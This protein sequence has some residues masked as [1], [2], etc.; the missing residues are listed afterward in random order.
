VQYWRLLRQP[1]SLLLWIGQVLSAAGDRLYAMAVLWLALELT[2]STEVMAAISAAESMVTMAVGLLI[3]A[4]ID[5]W[6]RVRTILT[7]DVI[8]AVIV[9]A[10]PVAYLC[11]KLDASLIVALC[12]GMAALD[13]VFNPALDA[14]LP[15]LVPAHQLPGLAGLMDTP[16]RFARLFGPGLAGVILTWI[17]VVGFYAIDA[18]TFAFSAL[19]LYLVR[20]LLKRKGRDSDSQQARVC[21]DNNWLQEATG[22]LRVVCKDELLALVLAMDCV[23]N[24]AF[25]AFTLGGL[26][27]ATRQLHMGLGA[28]G[29]LIAAYGVGS[30]LGNFAAGN[31]HLGRWR[32]HLAIAGWSGIGCGFLALG[33]SQRPLLGLAGIALAGACG[34]IAHVSRAVLL[35]DRVP[36]HDLGKV[37]ALKNIL[38]TLGGVMGTLVCGR[39]LAVWPAGWVLS[40]AGFV[41]LAT[42]AIAVWRLAAC[43]RVWQIFV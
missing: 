10:V 28:Y 12:I 18:V 16:D 3:G 35:A 29:T 15:S 38:T 5:H 6:H 41:L 37:Y 7:I 19:S 21:T 31:L 27:L 14:V 30:L 2:G 17:P 26:I 13:A 34:S 24:L 32:A 39:L 33:L 22:G 42:N 8:R 25:S 1:A 4:V 43:A 40:G 36:H 9:L 23:G 20:Q 11:G